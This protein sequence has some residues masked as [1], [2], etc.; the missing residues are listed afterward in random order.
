[1]THL[2]PFFHEHP[3]NP[4]SPWHPGALALPSHKSSWNPPNSSSWP[5]HLWASLLGMMFLHIFT[6]FCSHF[7][8]LCS[9]ITPPL[10]IYFR[11]VFSAITC[12]HL[13]PSLSSP[14]LYLWTSIAIWNCAWFMFAVGFN[15]PYEFNDLVN[16]ISFFTAS[17]LWA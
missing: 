7:F 14:L 12:C 2:S 1:M 3:R 6:Q 9:N 11:I 10:P 5:L 15:K 4:I 17:K 8:K 16:F 13:N